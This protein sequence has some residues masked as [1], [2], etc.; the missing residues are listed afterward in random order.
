MSTQLPDVLTLEQAATYLQLSE[1][2]LFRELEE[3]NIPGKKIAGKWRIRKQEIDNFLSGD[4][5]RNRAESKNEELELETDPTD[6]SSLLVPNSSFVEEVAPAQPELAS[7][8]PAIEP[9]L[10][11]TE[12]ATKIKST[13]E[14]SQQELPE[15]P[16]LP[17][18][19]VRATVFAYNIKEGYGY[20]RLVDNRVVWL[21]NK[22]LLTP[23][24]L[25]L[26]TDIIYIETTSSR[27]KG[28]EAR[29]I[30][31][32]KHL[33]HLQKPPG[34]NKLQKNPPKESTT[35][36]VEKDIHRA[37][38][39]KHGKPFTPPSRGT[40]RSQRIYQKAALA[41]AEGKYSE[42]RQLFYKAIEEG[43]GTAVYEAFI[44]MLSELKGYQPEAIRVAQRAIQV[45]PSHANFYIMYGQIER[46]AG[47]LQRAEKIFREGLLYSPNHVLLRFGLSQTLVQVGTEQSLREAGDIFNKLDKERKLNKSDGLYQ[48][49]IALRGNPRV[50]H[51]YD[52]FRSLNMKIGIAG[53]TR[54]N[55][56]TYATDVITEIN[57]Q[58]LIESF[59]LSES[60]G[61]LV[62]CF[63]KSPTQID[64]VNLT[65]YLREMGPQGIVGLQT[66]REIVLDSSLAF[67]AVP[68]SDAVR[69]Q[70]YNLLSEN[71][72]AIVP[73][74]DSDFKQRG[75]V[76]KSL[77]ILRE[78]LGQYLGQRDLYN[79]SMPVSGRRFFG[80]EQLLLQLTDD[81]QQGQF[82]GIYGLRKM[83]KTSLTYQLRDEKL[84]GDAVAYVDLQSSPAQIEKNCYPLYWEL[85]RD[86]YKR[87]ETEDPAAAKLLRLGN[88]ERFTD[89][90]NRTETGLIF[91]EDI[92]SFL[93]YLKDNQGQNYR[94]LVII[95]DELERILPVA[96]Q[97]GADGYLE[98]FGLIRGLAQTERYR[99]LVSS[100][101]VAANAA[102]S[103]RGYWDGRENP[104]FALYKPVFLP[105]LT[106][107]ESVEMIESLGK[108]MSVYWDQ[109][110]LDYV[111]RETGGHP[112][113]TRI[114]CSRI[115]RANIA[116]P[117][118]VTED[119]VV[120][121]IPEFMRDESDKLDQITELLRNNFPEEEVALQQIARG[122][123]P[124]NINDDTL[125][126]LL[127]YHLVRE[128]DGK[129]E[130]T[131][132]LLKRRL[133]RRAGIK[134]NE[135]P[136]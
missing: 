59:G 118:N 69:D 71:N 46:R 53:R 114:L 9:S 95:L 43:G 63:H 120:A 76:T 126:H 15:L 56:P 28:L 84:R 6:L 67:I 78:L 125:R 37:L 134:D 85:E 64:L 38:P 107:D 24:P 32:V 19:K 130:I 133:L 44:K 61:I 87:L 102:I 60:R 7:V 110:A 123:V 90:V 105:P 128:Q 12:P 66:G 92:R 91:S 68:R 16:E 30:Q 39:L 17:P 113:L 89:V 40:D 4:D 132:R 135:Q 62:R 82:I 57:H 13:E 109:G 94:R 65:K 31:I 100:V 131:I 129:Y 98:F 23:R 26:P 115:A 52:F 80:R 58:E 88:I 83:G 18:G 35:P 11:S 8:E 121:E 48:R 122:E 119:I 108:G 14:T 111:L 97:P 29:A 70:V 99:G 79:S 106:N 96:G 36:P 116:R 77:K 75:D 25:P 93:D 33:D 72:E 104:V 34:I 27:R 112:F 41:R 22:Y 10:G 74:D 45:F 47:N 124:N 73:I 54:S 2:E 55:L 51:T 42:A 49:F 86:L 5:G 117:L 127:S 21:E 101:V 50:G 136:V 20:A 1:D 103:E 81:V 3:G